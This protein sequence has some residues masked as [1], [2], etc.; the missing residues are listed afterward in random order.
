MAR[1]ASAPPARRLGTALE[2]PFPERLQFVLGTESGMIT[3]IVRKVQVRKPG[4][5]W[6]AG[7]HGGC[8]AGWTGGWLLLRGAC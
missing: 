1:R 7:L 4:G 5:A 8:V 2:Q 6:A 3:S